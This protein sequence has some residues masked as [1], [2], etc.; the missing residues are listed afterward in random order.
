MN[1]V[2]IS[3][4]PKIWAIVP[5]AGIGRR[6]H[7][8]VPKQ[9]LKIHGR[10]LM[11]HAI[12]RLLSVSALE[13]IVVVI[14]PN[15][16]LYKAIDL[17]RIDRVLVVTGGKSRY[18]SVLNGLTV[19]TDFAD[20]KDWV[21][22]HDVARPCIRTSDLDD[23]VEQLTDHCVG[24]LLGMPVRDTM[25]RIAS[26]REVTETINRETFWHAFTP[27]MFRINLLY[28]LLKKA[29]NDNITITDEA[30]VMEYAGFSPLMIEGHSDNI[31]VTHGADLA[32]AALYIQQQAK[33]RETL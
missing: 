28:E 26:N 13:K 11:E 3:Q 30:S 24:G 18:Y 9:Y 29:L 16:M 22:V 6:M 32:L 14:H 7:S 10:T 33:L 2:R 15:D 20:T 4:K 25:K 31:K 23:L 27:Q 1:T 8:S 17:L 12:E 5:A 21:M 19:L